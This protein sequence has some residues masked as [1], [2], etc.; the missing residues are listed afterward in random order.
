VPRFEFKQDPPD[1]EWLTRG[2]RLFNLAVRG[3]GLVL[4]VTGLI[5]ALTVIVSAWSLFEDPVRIENFARAVERG[6]N[7]DLTLA[8]VARSGQLE[9]DSGDRVTPADAGSPAAPAPAPSFR[10]SYFA[11]WL[12]ALLLLLL[13]GRLAIA[14]VRTGGELALYDVELRRLGRALVRERASP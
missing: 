1:A 12:L 14:A 4:L 10:F 13:I 3:L 8:K 2:D 11:A 9:L 6:S 5:V 7:L